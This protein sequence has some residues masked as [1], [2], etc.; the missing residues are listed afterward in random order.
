MLQLVFEPMI[1]VTKT[2][3]ITWLKNN[4]SLLIDKIELFC[5]DVGKFPGLSYVF[6]CLY[7]S[8]HETSLFAN[9]SARFLAGHCKLLLLKR[10][11]IKIS[12]LE[13]GRRS[14]FNDNP[15]H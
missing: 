10:N 9:V 2:V 5:F 15:D 12:R 6:S 14:Y 3:D 13:G 11:M 7:T 4:R 8:E 1:R